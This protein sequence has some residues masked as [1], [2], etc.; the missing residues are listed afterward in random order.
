MAKII[1]IAASLA[2][3]VLPPLAAA[4]SQQVN[5]FTFEDASCSAWSKSAGNPGLRMQY[6]SWLRGFVSGHNFANPANQVQIGAFPGSEQ[7][8]TY[9][10]GYCRENPKLNFAG[11]GIRMVEELRTATAP[12]R[13]TGASKSTAKS[14]TTK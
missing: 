3:A 7:V 14:A 6:E 11:A 4:Q 13:K 8:R 2:L 12:A 9:I 5:V 1:Q 10:D